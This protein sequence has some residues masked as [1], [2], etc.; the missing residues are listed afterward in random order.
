VSTSAARVSGGRW[1]PDLRRATLGR[2]D[3]VMGSDE[4]PDDAAELR[5]L[6]YAYNEEHTGYRDGQGLSCYLRDADGALLAGL[7]GFTW[8][9]YGRIE[10]LW[11]RADHRGRGLGRRLV[12][13]AVEEAR[14]RGASTIVLDTHTFQAL[15]FYTELGFVEVGRTTG[16]P[17]G[18]DQVLLQLD[19]DG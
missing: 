17:R 12:E 2:V 1:P 16:T 11:V 7:D 9:G 8:G 19:L 18:H 4:R 10:F 3:I 13:A 14:R 5:S 15:G 6:L